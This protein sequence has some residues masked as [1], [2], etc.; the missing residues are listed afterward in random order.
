MKCR[1]G[2]GHEDDEDEEDALLVT[3]VSRCPQELFLPIVTVNTDVSGLFNEMK[4][5]VSGSTLLINVINQF[6]FKSPSN[7]KDSKPLQIENKLFDPT[8]FRYKL[9][10]VQQVS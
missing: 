8:E 3:L 6:L 4:E 2:Y 9:S 1:P 5:T 10:L 7:I